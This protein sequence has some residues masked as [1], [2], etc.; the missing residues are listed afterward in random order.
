MDW[1]ALWQVAAP[2]IAD[3]LEYAVAVAAVVVSR[4]VVRWLAA[5]EAKANEEVAAIADVS[6][7]ATVSNLVAAAEQGLK[8][9]G[10][11]LGEAKF[12]QVLEWAQARG[13]DVDAA[14]IEAAV[15][16]LKAQQG[17]AK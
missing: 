10:E 11:K 13:L 16:R 9:E 14:D 8:A 3:L 15:A 4:Y 6:L 7:R 12:A 17:G 5:L 2:K 1:S